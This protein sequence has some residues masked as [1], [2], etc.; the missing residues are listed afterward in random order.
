MAGGKETPRQKMIGMMYLVLTALLALNVSKQILDAFVAIEE[1][2]Q[3]SAQ[4]SK[5]IGDLGIT[6]MKTAMAEKTEAS[7]KEKVKKLLVVA[8]QIDKLTAQEIK[9]IDD[10]KMELLK[11]CNEEVSIMKNGDGET[12]LWEKTDGCKPAILHLMAVNNKEEYDKPME[13]LIGAGAEINAPKKDALGMKIFEGIAKYRCDLVNLL[14]TWDNGEKKYTVKTKPLND[15]KDQADLSKKLDKMFK[16]FT[17]NGDEEAQLKKLYSDL[18]LAE[19]VTAGETENA[20]WVG[21]TFDHSPLVAALASMT[22][23]QQSILAARA[24][25]IGLLKERA[26]TGEYSFNKV[27]ALAY[28]PSSVNQNEEYEVKVLM[29]AYDTDNNP[30]VPGAAETKDGVAYMR[31]KGSGSE[32]NLSGTVS[33]R[34]KDGSMKTQP[35]QTKIVV[36]KP[37]GTVSLPDMNVLYRGYPNKIEGVASGYDQTLL[38]S[39]TVSLSKSGTGWIGTVGN[40]KEASITISGKSSVTNKTVSLGA[41]KFRVRGL[42]KPSLYFGG[43]E[44]GGQASKAETK[45]FAKYGPEIPLN[46]TFSI[47]SWELNVS[48]APRPAKGTGGTLSGEGVNFLKQAKP[49]SMVSFMTQVRFPDG[50]VR[51]VGGSYRI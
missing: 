4:K 12:I 49:G 51:K 3:N 25:A 8:D 10:A 7:A 31:G 6:D 37:Q 34:K 19:K 38:S 17:V 9:R 45:L 33:I 32:V 27:M 23:L 42:P 39:S 35:W 15:F 14:G 29:A 36:M 41:F 2:S 24:D 47:L 22:S 16:S 46:V 50:S 13:L 43:A 20:H 44:D 48:G 30:I 5:V 26:G 18:S 1:N 11:Y 21:K 40:I 28:G